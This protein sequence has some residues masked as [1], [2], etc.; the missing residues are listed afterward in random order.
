MFPVMTRAASFG[1]LNCHRRTFISSIEWL[2]LLP[3]A[4]SS[5]PS[6]LLRRGGTLFARVFGLSA[7]ERS[8]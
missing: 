1:I 6:P 5:D 3:A 7:R 4:A 2:A 8:E